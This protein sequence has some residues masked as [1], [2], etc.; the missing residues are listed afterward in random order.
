[1]TSV[2]LR[3][4]KTARDSE[5]RFPLVF[6]ILHEGRKKLVSTK[7][8]LAEKEFDPKSE[9]I[10]SSENG[11][12]S[13]QKV[14]AM[15]RSLN[16]QR[17]SL[18]ER[19]K[20]L[21]LEWGTYTVS[22]IVGI[23]E[24]KSMICLIKSLDMCISRCE[25]ENRTGM[26]AAF[27]STKSSLKGFLQGRS[28][29]LS[30]INKQF[31]RDYESYLICKGV[32]RNTIA[33]YL[34][35]IRTVYNLFVDKGY[36]SSEQYPFSEV[37]T[38]VYPTQK[39]ALKRED[40]IRLVELNFSESENHLDFARDFFLFSFYSRGMSMVDILYLKKKDIK[41]GCIT[42]ER[43]KSK[44]LLQIGVT[45]PLQK[46]IDKYHHDGEY[47]FP[48]LDET[49]ADSLY[50]QYRRASSRINRNLK[51]IGTILQF[52]ITLTTY[53][54]RHSWATQAKILGAPIGVIS[55]GLGHSSESITRIYLK[56]LDSSVIDR[57]NEQ[58][59][60]LK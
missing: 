28:I 52:S 20:E 50:M 54:A 60:A 15:H 5:G 10:L 40:I 29:Y 45:E 3:L 17:R 53:V 11:D 51:A 14:G 32:S 36:R 4:N 12:F 8:R 57:I 2:K 26:A 34:R 27:K 24:N 39:R 56:E 9:R 49:A 25:K 43:K 18:L 23:R 58:I 35:N 42:Y 46:I 48:V 33:Y 44:Q 1:M 38:G 41:G 47:I 31:I 13:I 19:I 22:D 59:V 6:Q 30:S 21:E 37:K 16:K 7:Y 55:E